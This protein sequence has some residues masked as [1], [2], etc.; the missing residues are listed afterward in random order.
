MAGVENPR[1]PG[2]PGISRRSALAAAGAL[3]LC[4]TGAGVGW[5][6]RRHLDVP[7][8]SAT[9]AWAGPGRRSFVSD[10]QVGRI[11]PGTRVLKTADHSGA[12]ASSDREWLAAGHD[13]VI[14]DHRFAAMARAAL[15]DMKTMMMPNGAALAAWSPHWRYVW[16]RDSAHIAAALSSAGH[17]DDA[18]TIMEF[19][20]RAMPTTGWL[21]SRYLPD[22]SGPP[23]GR[24]RQLD[25]FGWVLWGAGKM[26]ADAGSE[27]PAV[28]RRFRRLLS[29]C[30]RGTLAA[31][32]NVDSLPPPS[33]DYWEQHENTLTLGIAAPLLAG[34]Q[35]GATIFGLVGDA[36]LG[37]QCARGAQRLNKAIE[38]RFG[39]TGYPRV[40]GKSAR[41]ASV[42]MLLPPYTN[43]A[44]RDVLTA[45]SEART[46]MEQSNGGLSPGADWAKD[47]VA[48][49]PETAMFAYVYAGT[50][51]TGKAAS[52]LQWLGDHRTKAGSLSEKV[53]FSGE[54]AAVAPLSWTAA[55]TVL[56]IEELER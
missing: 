55:L 44:R 52:L 36:D 45:M 19:L 32:N 4:L 33:M 17:R 34:L 29:Y 38:V 42:A 20:Q 46:S 50:G 25:N 49:T 31:I 3:G 12:L 27:A 30:A 37:R 23:D 2:R 7:L 24:E 47:G 18:V 43:A 16:P 21:E 22:G 56:T 26:A 51:Q 14:R 54:P 8:D 35:A 6:R 48:W 5:G 13:W 9:I 11:I 1:V 41:D 40:L 28:L 53:L 39:S 10:A 15:L